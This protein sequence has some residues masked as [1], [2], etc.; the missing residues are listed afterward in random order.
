MKLN[1]IIKIFVWILSYKKFKYIFWV[2]LIK[3]ENNDKVFNIK[4][5]ECEEL[6]FLIWILL[7]KI[8]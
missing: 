1:V 4:C 2:K 5:P 6:L 8:F 3:M 7:M